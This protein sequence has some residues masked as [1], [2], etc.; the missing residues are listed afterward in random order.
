MVAMATMV[1]AAGSIAAPSAIAQ[2]SGPVQPGWEPRTPIELLETANYLLQTGRD[3]QAKTYLDRF[4]K[5]RPIDL[6]A[7]ADSWMRTGRAARAVP[8]LSQFFKNRPDD[9]TLIAIRNQ[10]G[11]RS[12]RQL[13]DNP[14]TRPFAQPMR[15]ALAA[16][17][18]RTKAQSG[19]RVRSCSPGTRGRP[20]SCGMPSIT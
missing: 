6:W 4:E 17:E 2:Q 13:D 1:L 8:Y 18:Q 14:A 5:S 11:A 3:R 9:A 12:I 16:A 19:A 10:F 7:A 15:V 20:S